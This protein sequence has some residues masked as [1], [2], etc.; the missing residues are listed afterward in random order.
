MLAMIVHIKPANRRFFFP[1]GSAIQSSSWAFSWAIFHFL[2]NWKELILIWPILFLQKASTSLGTRFA[3]STRS[4]WRHEESISYSS[5]FFHIFTLHS[6]SH[7]G[8][9]RISE[10]ITDFVSRAKN[11]FQEFRLVSKINMCI[12]LSNQFLEPYS[13][14]Y[15]MDIS[16]NRMVFPKQKPVCNRVH[17]HN[18]QKQCNQLIIKKFDIF[19]L[20]GREKSL[21]YHQQ[22]TNW[23]THWRLTQH[24]LFRTVITIIKD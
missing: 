24:V 8:R 13:N 2:E 22:H 12:H 9:L 4:R 6:C 10:M 11:H 1:F 20:F 23:Y 17:H 18:C 14:I 3:M 7:N 16:E 5:R 19:F 15:I 21:K